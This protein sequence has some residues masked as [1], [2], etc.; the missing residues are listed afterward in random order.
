[1]NTIIS[2][3]NDIT[4]EVTI[5]TMFGGIFQFIYT[6]DRVRI[7][8]FMNGIV[9]DGKINSFIQ[10][11]TEGKSTS[12]TMNNTD[13]SLFVNIKDGMYEHCSKSYSDMFSGGKFTCPMSDTI[14]RAWTQ[15]PD[16]LK[17][18]KESQKN[19]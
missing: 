3:G 10:D 1:M 17:L 14:L 11:M 9:S 16:A 12:L 7:E 2:K 8:M 4:V 18:Y 5:D 19:H 6:I 15:V 13:G